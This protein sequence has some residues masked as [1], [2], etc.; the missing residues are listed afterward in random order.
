MSRLLYHTAGT[1]V[2]A[3]TGLLLAV[4]LLI[5]AAGAGLVRL[6]LAAV[7]RDAIRA[8]AYR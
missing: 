8:G 2:V 4:P 6:W 5:G 1:A 7:D 3:A